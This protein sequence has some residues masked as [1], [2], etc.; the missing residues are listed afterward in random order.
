MNLHPTNKQL[1]IYHSHCA[2][3]F[4]SAWCFYNKAQKDHVILDFYPGIYSESPPDCTGA[5][6]Y[7]VD[8]SYK[9]DVVKKIC[10][11]ASKVILID[12]HKT[13]IE[14]LKPLIDRAS[15]EF[16]PNFHMYVD[17]ESSGARLAWDFLYNTIYKDNN[18]IRTTEGCVE[19][20]DPPILLTHVEDRDL[21]HF[22]LP[23]SKEVNSYI[24]S[25]DYTFEQ[26]DILMKVD[27]AQLVSVIDGGAS[28]L[29]KHNKD[30][31]E[32]LNVCL[33]YFRIGGILVPVASLPYIHA[34]DAGHIMAADWNGGREFAACYWDTNTHR[35][36]SLR[37]TP[38]GMDVSAIASN[39]G[40][41]GHKNAAGFRVT[42]DDP[43]A[44]L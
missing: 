17:L 28:I 38:T 41:G 35:V 44:V 29:R 33:R 40:G 19:Y 12:H 10:A 31:K 39:Y 15:E 8:F 13:A 23:C 14:D 42:R 37:S 32:L 9:K 4:T 1:V 30:I 2:D 26:W 36:F 34:S 22:K 11:V 43:L 20:R 7:L 5:Y 18:F 24:F 16:T 27:S 3:G 21:W 6:V 25:F